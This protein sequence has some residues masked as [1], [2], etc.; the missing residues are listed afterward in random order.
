MYKAI[1]FRTGVFLS[2]GSHRFGVVPITVVPIKVV[3]ITMVPIDRRIY[4]S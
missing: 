2:V 3:P 4:L 1:E